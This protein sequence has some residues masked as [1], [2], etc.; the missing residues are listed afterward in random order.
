MWRTKRPP[1]RSGNISA[2]GGPDSGRSLHAAAAQYLRA[3]VAVA[4]VLAGKPLD[5]LA[6]RYLA[7]L[8]DR[9]CESH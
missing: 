2:P 3:E 1:L 9:L 6:R 4:E 8:R 5:H 7:T